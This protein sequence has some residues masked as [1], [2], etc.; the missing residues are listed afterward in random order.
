MWQSAVIMLSLLPFSLRIN[1][2]LIPLQEVL[3][4]DL[5]GVLRKQN[6]IPD[7]ESTTLFSSVSSC[8]KANKSN[9][10]ELN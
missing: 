2:V 5:G 9:L 10:W 6:S 8:S 4:L 1:L 7:F 3:T